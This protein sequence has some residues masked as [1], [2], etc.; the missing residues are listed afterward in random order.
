MQ[1]ACTCISSN[2]VVAEYPKIQ[3][4]GRDSQRMENSQGSSLKICFRVSGK[5]KPILLSVTSHRMFRNAI[6][7]MANESTQNVYCSSL[8]KLAEEEDV[9]V[10]VTAANCFATV[11]DGF[12]VKIGANT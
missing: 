7:I 12:I 4:L 3:F 8:A 5:P 10:S 1:S 6:R 2:F 11:G 9:Y